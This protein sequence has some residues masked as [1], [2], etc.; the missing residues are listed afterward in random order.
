MA[1]L[2]ALMLLAAAP[3]LAQRVATQGQGLSQGRDPKVELFPGERGQVVPTALPQG[4]GTRPGRRGPV[5]EARASLRVEQGPGSVARPALAAEAHAARPRV[6]ASQGQGL[7]HGDEPKPSRDFG[8]RPEGRAPEAGDAPAFYEIFMTNPGDGDQDG[9][10]D[11]W[12]FEIDIDPDFGNFTSG[13][14]I[15]VEDQFGNNWG[16]FGPYTFVGVQSGDNIVLADFMVPGLAQESYV[17]FY[18]YTYNDI[19]YSY[20]DYYDLPADLPADYPVFYD[21][22]VVNPQNLDGDQFLEMWDFEL[23]IDAYYGDIADNV[24]IEV[25]DDEGN[26]WG[27][28]GPFDFQGQGNADNILITDFSY[29]TYGFASGEPVNFAFKAYNAYGQDTEN[30]TVAVDQF[31]LAPTFYEVVAVNTSDLDADN[32]FD[33]WDFEI[34][35]DG[36]GGLARDVSIQIT[37]NQGNDWGTF[38]PFDFEGETDTDNVLITDFSYDNYDMPNPA[39]VLFTFRAFNS[40]GQDVE[41]LNLWVDTYYEAPVFYE[42]YA[43]NTIDQDQDGNY[44]QWDF[45]VDIDAPFGGFAAQV[46]VQITDNQGNDWGTYGPYNFD[47]ETA[48]DNFIITPWNMSDYDFDTPQDVAFTFY[49]YNDKGN[50]SRSLQVPVDALSSDASLS[51]IRV[52]GV[53]LP[54]FSPST[55]SYTRVL[56]YGTTAIP[57][58]AGTTTSASA[59]LQV[60]QATSLSGSQAQR[61]ATLTVTAQDGTTTRAYTV[62]FQVEPPSDDASLAALRIDGQNLAGF[63]SNTL[64]YTFPVAFTQQNIPVASATTNHPQASLQIQQATDLDGTQQQRTATLTVMAQDGTTTRAYTVEFIRQPPSA[65]ASLSDLRVNNQTVANFNPQTLTYQV[66]MPFSTQQVPLVAGTLNFPF[67]SLSVQ[68][69]QSID[70]TLEQR[71]A[72]LTVTAEDGTTQR[73][74]TVEFFRLPASQ[75]ASLSDLRVSGQTVAGFSPQTLAYFVTLPFGTTQIPN[76]SGTTNDPYASLQTQQAT[77]LAGDQ[78]QRTATLTVTAE[79]GQTTR[80]YAVTFDLA[81]ASQDARLSDLRINGQTIPG[82]HP[83]TINYVHSWPRGQGMPQVSVTLNDPNADFILQNPTNLEGTEAQRTATITVTAQD[84]TTTRA[85]SVLFNLWAVSVP[86]ILPLEVGIFPNPSQGRAWLRLPEG[87]RADQAALFD[88]AG[89]MVRQWSGPSLQAESPELSLE[90]LAA[91]TYLLRLRASDGRWA[92]QPLVLAP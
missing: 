50:D 7:E 43:I 65:D 55:T 78:Q 77:S 40:S 4:Q 13:V 45:E 61:T 90:G 35:I 42:V 52:D 29:Q 26:F 57:S 69:A 60:Q 3:A 87:I 54:G 18:F 44:E 86:Q 72:T 37:D 92:T 85:Y 58:V 1:T 8:P 71:T 36:I 21:A 28:F 53:P 15:R 88:L 68:Q 76:V 34:D 19:G 83:N 56:P 16:D 25:S 10:Y 9:F 74:Y 20:Y 49:A 47:R 17:D 79:D 6:T 12:D 39:N 62:E 89:A 5:A 27:P 82:F 81:P 73:A 31:A 75:D 22:Y 80:Q 91:G 63:S 11:I 30:Q 46:F 32:R 51:S 14:F 66:G 23:D 41:T 59:S 84:G 70:G 64:T 38:G 67:A 48:D 33:L 24:M 2:F